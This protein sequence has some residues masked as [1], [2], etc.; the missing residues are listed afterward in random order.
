MQLYFI[1][2]RG[3]LI[4]INKYDF[5]NEDV[6]VTDDG[7]SV[8]IWYG[9]SASKEKK[10]AALRT[11]RHIVREKVGSAKI[12][13][14]NQNDEYGAFLA[15]MD[16]LRGGILE[17]GSFKPRPELDL[18]EIIE[19]PEKDIGLESMFRVAAYYISLENYTY[20]DLCWLLAEKH[21]IIMKGNANITEDD[22][23]QKAEEVYK[24]S[25]TYDELCWLMGEL[26]ILIDQGYIE[27]D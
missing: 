21:L 26:D 2:D 13:L 22:I 17:D 6:Y 20:D 16:D 8:Y 1:S 9:L 23:K 14:M 10:E 18:E 15:M 4:K 7:S 25:T 3:F 24:S 27:I 12:L 5:L 11:A 19:G